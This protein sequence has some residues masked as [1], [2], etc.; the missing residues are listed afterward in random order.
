ME[1]AAEIVEEVWGEE[2]LMAEEEEEKIEI[3]VEVWWR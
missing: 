1:E 2:G 3:F